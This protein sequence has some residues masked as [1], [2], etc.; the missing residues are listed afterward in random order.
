MNIEEEYDCSPYNENC[1]SVSPVHNYKPAMFAEAHVFKRQLL[2]TMQYYPGIKFKI[3]W[4]AHDFGKYTSVIV[5]TDNE[6]AFGYLEDNL[7][8]NWD[9]I[10][11]DEIICSQILK[12]YWTA[13]DPEY[14]NELTRRRPHE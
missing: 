2:R 7:P 14:W 11:L 8:A 3:I 1:V 9:D 4:N 12:D 6:D 13:V 10:S 5:Q